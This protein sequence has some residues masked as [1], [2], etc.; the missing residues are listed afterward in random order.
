[1]DIAQPIRGLWLAA[2]V[3]VPCLV[4][5]A[6][7][8]TA[9]PT[10]AHRATGTFIL[11]P[12]TEDPLSTG[13]VAPYVAD[14]RSALT[15]TQVAETVFDVA[16]T[17]QAVVVASPTLF[18][19]ENGTD[20]A[21]SV[22]TNDSVASAEIARAVTQ[23]ALS[24][25]AD[26][27]LEQALVE[28]D[29]ENV[30]LRTTRIAF[31]DFQ[32]THGVKDVANEYARRSND[33][34]VLRTALAAETD[35]AAQGQLESL[36]I[37]KSA[38]RDVYGAALTDWTLLEAALRS[39]DQGQI[40]AQ[41]RFDVLGLWSRDLAILASALEVKVEAESTARTRLLRVVVAMFA[42]ALTVI[43]LGWAQARHRGVIDQHARS[44]GMTPVV[45]G[46]ATAVIRPPALAVARPKPAAPP[47]QPQPQPQRQ[48]Q[49]V[50]IT[51]AGA[52]AG[53]VVSAR[54]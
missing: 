50:D 17:Q 47:A 1:M 51:P 23:V 12:P 45:P 27:Q 46:L 19:S 6:V 54:R 3:L 40:D 24:R 16:T 36:L 18:V 25:L 37:D 32:A 2:L 49:P 8:V 13:S 22:T 4:G 30:E 44:H 11:I 41:E 31:N 9:R 7:A 10:A 5:G 20:V 21:V 43:A 28:L 34:L 35:P 42:T 39:A 53:S 26:K 38:E 15:S 14:L 48:L 52:G 33:L 29:A